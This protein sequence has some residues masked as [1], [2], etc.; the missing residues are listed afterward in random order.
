MRK[1]GYGAL[2]RGRGGVAVGF[3]LLAL[4]ASGCGRG[5]T[6]ADVTGTPTVEATEAPTEESSL[7]ELLD[8]IVVLE[9]DP[10]LDIEFDSGGSGSGVASVGVPDGPPEVQTAVLEGFADGVGRMFFTPKLAEAADLG[11]L[12][13]DRPGY[14]MINSAAAAYEDEA[15]AQ[16]AL[17]VVLEEAGKKE[18]LKP[19]AEGMQARAAGTMT[20]TLK[21]MGCEYEGP[22]DVSVGQ[23][24]SQ[25]VNETKGQ[26]DL[27]LWLLNAG[28]P[29]DELAAHIAEEE[30]RSKLGEPGLGYPTFATLVAEATAD[31]G[32]D[33]ELVTD[34][35]VGT[36]GMACIR[37]G[38]GS[39]GGLWATGPFT[40]S[41]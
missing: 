12:N 30:R 23:V 13:Y 4:L 34:L 39:G 20:V 29:Y 33:G 26:F 1:R 5:G 31:A 19:I 11:K 28:H 24:T 22:A 6:Q 37:F 10:P 27:D 36:Y 38:P 8:L 2:L 17:E 35:A 7:H 14:L 16:A 32:L 21:K 40:V 18:W 9:A 25:M 3:S 15:S 41:E